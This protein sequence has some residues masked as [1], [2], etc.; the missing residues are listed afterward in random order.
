MTGDE[1]FLSRWSRRKRAVRDGRANA[2]K[3]ESEAPA[4]DT[5][6]P[7]DSAA[8]RA[9][10]PVEAKA[11]RDLP[12]VESLGKDSDYAPFLRDGVPDD[13]RR[14]ALSRLWASDPALA[15]PD[16][17]DL[18]N[19]DFRAPAAA[20]AVATLFRVGR[21]IVDP[22]EPAP[23]AESDSKTD[24]VEPKPAE[25][26]AGLVAPEQTCSETQI[27]ARIPESG[28]TEKADKKSG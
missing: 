22:D 1:T 13:L 3:P 17:L 5:L 19:L 26:Q 7:A 2:D 24:A 4:S 6:A 10:A 11:P 18:Y 8:A 12:P 27:A 23:V 21:G 20:E 15:A 14:Q 16:P 28:D 25:P 9:D